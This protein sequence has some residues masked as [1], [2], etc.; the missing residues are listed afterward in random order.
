MNI[1]VPTT[2]AVTPVGAGLA[3]H[4]DPTSTPVT[5]RLSLLKW[6]KV[7]WSDF[8]HIFNSTQSCSKRHYNIIFG[9]LAAMQCHLLA[10]IGQLEGPMWPRYSI[11]QCIF[12]GGIIVCTPKVVN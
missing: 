1:T 8:F 9:G 12:N 11:L 6:V 2:T 3:T 10:M 4:W 5:V 7:A